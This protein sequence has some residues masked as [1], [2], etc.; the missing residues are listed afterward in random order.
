[1]GPLFLPRIITPDFSAGA[2]Q[3][4]KLYHVPDVEVP[5]RESSV[6]RRDKEEIRLERGKVFETRASG[7]SVCGGILS[8]G[9][10]KNG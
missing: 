8:R 9:E 10:S 6:S 7:W 2:S 1:M 4:V 3:D 5:L